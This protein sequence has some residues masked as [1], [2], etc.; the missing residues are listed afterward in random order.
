[1]SAV[2]D[3]IAGELAAPVVD[4]TGLDGM[5]DVVI[6]YEPRRFLLGGGPAGL[7]PNS[8][9]SPKLPLP[10]AIERQLG[11]KLEATTGDIPT[12]VIDAAEK[13]TPD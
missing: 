6:E 9:E 5:Y 12:V 8:T 1:M 7:D 10:N 4:R 2:V 3:H 11:L 13:P